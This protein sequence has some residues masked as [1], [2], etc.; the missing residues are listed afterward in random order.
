MHNS[1]FIKAISGRGGGG[2]KI[3]E[4]I[5]QQQQHIER[6]VS[7]MIFLTHDNMLL[8]SLYGTKSYASARYRYWDVVTVNF[9]SIFSRTCTAG[10]FYQWQPWDARTESDCILG[11]D[12][13]LERRLP[14]RCCLIGVNYDRP[15]SVSYCDCN[16]DDYEWYALVSFLSN[17]SISTS[18]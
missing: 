14:Q 6:Y 8:C 17:F 16:I 11:L 18:L 10:D 4:G 3:G 5:I 9:S 15:I 12:V 2:R 13:T 1:K 7:S